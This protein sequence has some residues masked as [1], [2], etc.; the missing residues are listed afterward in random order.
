[1]SVLN[2]LKELFDHMYWADG[3]VWKTVLSIPESQNHEQLKKIIYH[4]HLTQYAFY[5]LWMELPM[6]FKRL[7]DF[8]SLSEMSKWALTYDE[9]VSPFLSGLK[10]EQLEK[11]VPIPW[12]GRLEKLIGKNPEDATLGETMFH[13]TAH[14]AY[15]RGQVNS[16][17][18]SLGGEPPL[19]DYIAWV[20]LGK[21]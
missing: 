17:I 10:E 7:S 3:K 20:W 5:H 11:V 13:V 12:S 9:L 16:L 4:Y 19:V 18:R 8:D 2:H 15:H 6:E 14:S 21:P 1:M